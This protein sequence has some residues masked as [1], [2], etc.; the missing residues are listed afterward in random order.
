MQRRGEND[1]HSGAG[2][3]VGNT[4]SRNGEKEHS[5]SIFNP[6]TRLDLAKLHGYL[7]SP[8]YENKLFQLWQAHCQKYGMPMVWIR[9]SGDRASVIVWKHAGE[10]FEFPNQIAQDIPP[11][12]AKALGWDIFMEAIRLKRLAAHKK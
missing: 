10:R 2:V 11:A 8:R 5:M 3:S 9:P 1:G 7:T 6:S 4:L 12:E